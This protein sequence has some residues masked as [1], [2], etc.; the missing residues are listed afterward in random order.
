LLWSLA[1]ILTAYWLIPK[2]VGHSIAVGRG[3]FT[4]GENERHATW[5]T[6]N[7]GRI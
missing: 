7:A 3:R 1:P 6:T 2:L 4:D 5:L